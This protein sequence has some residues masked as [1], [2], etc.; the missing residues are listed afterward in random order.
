MQHLT[1][2]EVRAVLGEKTEIDIERM[3]AIT[4]KHPQVEVP[5]QERFINGL[6]AREILIPKGTLL[7]GRV[8]KAGYLDIMLSGDISVATPNGVKRMTGTNIMEAPPGRKRAGYAFEDTHWITV[9]RTDHFSPG[10]MLEELTFFSLGEYRRFIRDRDHASYQSVIDAMGMTEEEVQ[11][12]VQ[13]ESDMIKLSAPYSERVSVAP[14]IIHGQ[15][16]VACE[17]FDLGDV[18]GPARNSYGQRTIIGR[19]GNHSANPNAVMELAENNSVWLVAT[20]M[21]NA[22]DEITTHYGLTLQSVH[23]VTACQ[24]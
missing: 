2:N 22:G 24:E 6:Y 12:Q 3:E 7:T 21:I 1:E 5:T 10:D 13:N 11:R 23:G 20:R 16:L 9:H 18:I 17:N 4:R 8:Y 14:S 19:Y 15:G